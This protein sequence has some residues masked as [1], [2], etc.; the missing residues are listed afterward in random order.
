M[1]TQPNKIFTAKVVTPCL[2][3]EA[4]IG[5][6]AESVMAQSAVRPGRL[7]LQY[8][9]CDGAS[10]DGTLEIVRQICGDRADI[11]S[12]RDAGMYEALAGGLGHAPGDVVSYLN[13]G[14]V[15]PDCAGRRS[16]RLR[17]AS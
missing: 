12:E 10:T 2:N 3:G 13:A 17:A 16:R 15:R 5:R 4:L 7:R 9:V 6:T 14:D 1:T 8:V 11:V